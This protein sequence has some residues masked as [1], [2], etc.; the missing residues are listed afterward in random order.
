[1]EN[2]SGRV[3]AKP[4][5]LDISAC[6][7]VVQAGLRSDGEPAFPQTAVAGNVVLKR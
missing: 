3:L 7:A 2:H 6:S 4:I 5:G 1:M